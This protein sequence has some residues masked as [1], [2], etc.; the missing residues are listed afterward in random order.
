MSIFIWVFKTSH[1]YVVRCDIFASAKS[2]AHDI[3]HTRTSIDY[4]VALFRFQICRKP[5][6]LCWF[7]LFFSSSLNSITA[8]S[9][10]SVCCTS[11]SQTKCIQVLYKIGRLKFF[12]L[13]LQLLSIATM[14][15]SCRLNAA[16]EKLKQLL[17]SLRVHVCTHSLF[18]N[19]DTNRVRQKVE[20]ILYFF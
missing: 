18:R 3:D 8:L 4:S 13:S 14:V 6:S 7:T 16:K 5:F 19:R 12:F 17:P 1:L 2:I 10:S 20:I 11:I 9:L 15:S